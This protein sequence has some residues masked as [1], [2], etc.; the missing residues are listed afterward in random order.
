M[1]VNLTFVMIVTFREGH[2]ETCKSAKNCTRCSSVI[3][4][5]YLVHISTELFWLEIG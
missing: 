4:S 2:P 5:L 1:Y 3:I